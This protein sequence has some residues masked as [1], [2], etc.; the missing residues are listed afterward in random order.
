MR[1]G[2]GM[3]QDLKVAA[4]SLMAWVLFQGLASSMQSYLMK[5][6][7]WRTQLP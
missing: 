5:E 2:S 7:N 6:K 3:A 4:S 1:L